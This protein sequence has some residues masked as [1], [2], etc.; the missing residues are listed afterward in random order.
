MPTLPPE[1][2][3]LAARV[4]NWG[5]WG[6]DDEIGTLNLITDAVVRR[7]AAAIRQGRRLTLGIPLDATGPQTG[8]IPGRVNPIHAMLEVN[9]PWVRGDPDN[10]CN[11]DDMIVMGLQACTHWDALAH[12]SYEGRIYNG[13]PATVVTS[14]GASRCGIDKVQTIVSRGVLL[15]VARVKAV[16]RI[17]GR[18]AITGEDLDAAAELARVRILPGDVVFVRTGHIQLLF[19]G[20]RERFVSPAPGLSLRSVEWFRRHDVAAVGSDNFTGEVFPREL[21]DTYLPVHLLHLVEMGMTQGQNFN[22]EELAAD[23]AGDGQYDF[24]VDA[25]PQRFTG[26]VGTPVNP[27]V[28]K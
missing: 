4:R 16:E 2:K 14:R 10:F 20:Q 17:E 23:C 9:Q 13:F 27:V 22:L 24:F 19:Q 11:S 1:V 15:D 12:V 25:S 18:Y 3:E 7:A 26:A 5:R 6:A 28:I 8:V 21:K